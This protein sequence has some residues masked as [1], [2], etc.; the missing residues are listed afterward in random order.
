LLFQFRFFNFPDSQKI[1]LLAR[2]RNPEVLPPT[3]LLEHRDRLAELF[4]E[5]RVHTRLPRLL[6]V[7]HDL[8]HLEQRGSVERNLDL[9]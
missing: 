5:F 2:W 8:S 4:H 7:L 9:D 1:K 3:E 6:P